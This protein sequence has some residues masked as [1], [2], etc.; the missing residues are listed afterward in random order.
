MPG[1]YSLRDNVRRFRIPDQAQRPDLPFLERGLE[2]FEQSADLRGIGGSFDDIGSVLYLLGR[3]DEAYEKVTVGQP[4][5]L[6]ID[7]SQNGR[8]HLTRPVS[9]SS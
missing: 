8:R 6:G 1:E 3:Y 9:L 5:E 7:A 4:V 2:L